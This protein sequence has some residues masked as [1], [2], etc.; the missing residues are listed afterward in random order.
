MG[1][2]TL[3]LS[4]Y[5][6]ARYYMPPF[7]YDDYEVVAPSLTVTV[8]G[9]TMHLIGGTCDTS[10]FGTIKSKHAQILAQ[11]KQLTTL[12]IC[13]P[14]SFNH[15]CQS[16]F[17]WFDEVIEHLH[18]LQV[19][20]KYLNNHKESTPPPLKKTYTQLFFTIYVTI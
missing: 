11:H 14:V 15:M 6:V 13:S 16:F 17:T 18:E 3:L 12:I 7:S 1:Y 4:L 5:P 8:C 2:V 19:H 10:T 9:T 20:Q